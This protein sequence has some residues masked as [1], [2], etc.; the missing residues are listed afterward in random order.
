MSKTF[1]SPNILRTYFKLLLHISLEY[2]TFYP[3]NNSAK[4]LSSKKNDTGFFVLETEPTTAE[5]TI[6]YLRRSVGVIQ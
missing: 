2:V 3:E 6:S 5:R 1:N 4:L